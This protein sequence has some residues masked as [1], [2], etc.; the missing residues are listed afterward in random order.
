MS[1]CAEVYHRGYWS[2]GNKNDLIHNETRVS[3]L[4]LILYSSNY[5]TFISKFFIFTYYLKIVT[6]LNTV[7][8]KCMNSNLKLI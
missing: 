1:S 2:K 5:Y 6:R 3:E 7:K 4:E 8:Q